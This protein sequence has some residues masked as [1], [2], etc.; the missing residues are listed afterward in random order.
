MH[1]YTKKQLIR[2]TK[3][4]MPNIQPSRQ[5]SITNIDPYLFDKVCLALG[6]KID[7]VP[8]HRKNMFYEIIL[9]FIEDKSN[10][11]AADRLYNEKYRT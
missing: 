5:L 3:L 9:E 10:R 1:C 2:K 11:E 7:S 8:D 4:E 6:I